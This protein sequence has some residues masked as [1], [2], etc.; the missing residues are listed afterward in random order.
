MGFVADPRDAVAEMARVARPG[1]QVLVIDETERVARAYRRPVT[2][3]GAPGPTV[4]PMVLV[5][6]C[7]VEPEL[8]VV[9]KG[10]LYRLTFRT[11]PAASA[12]GRGQHPGLER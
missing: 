6:P 12:E 4:N 7:M 11:P 8:A 9:A 2:R 5:P 3:T 10:E 1:A